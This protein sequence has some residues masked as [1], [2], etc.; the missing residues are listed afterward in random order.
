MHCHRNSRATVVTV[1]ILACSIWMLVE[2]G[3]L[4]GTR[5]PNSCGPDLRSAA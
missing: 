2:I 5:E 1:V 3:F 4:R